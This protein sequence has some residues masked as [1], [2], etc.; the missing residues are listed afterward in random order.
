VLMWGHANEH[1]VLVGSDTGVSVSGYSENL[2]GVS[3][4]CVRSRIG[5]SEQG[6]ERP[7]KQRLPQYLPQYLPQ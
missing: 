4:R 1:R 5:F 7:R 6:E 2:S 3:I